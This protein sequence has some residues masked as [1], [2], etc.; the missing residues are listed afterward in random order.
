MKK[1]KHSVRTFRPVLETSPFAYREAYKSLRTNLNFVS[2]NNQYKTIGITSAIPGEGKT[3]ISINL[4]ITLAE[5]GYHIMLVDCD[6]RRPQV[7]K[8]LKIHN[9][10]IGVSTI[11]SG[12]ST[13]EES[14]F[15]PSQFAVG[16]D[17]LCAGLIPPNPAELLGGTKMEE[18][19]AQLK[20]RYDYV[21]FD[22]PPAS[23]VTDSSELS[24]MLD[25]VV[26]VVQQ[27]NT[28]IDL[29][30]DAKKRL[31]SVDA[32]IIGAVLNNYKDMTK[33]SGYRSYRRYGYK[34]G[35]KYGYGYGYGER[36][37]RKK[38]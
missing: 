37:S 31:E 5:A 26:L 1:G 29:V 10:E 6:L 23:L 35:Y 22:T 25:G 15:N 33:G 4:A 13:L 16:V 27:K 11:L 7:H 24:R 20:E 19:I 28:R 3:S 8:Y 2:V 9:N 32:N 21:I 17:V 38:S 34:Y 12:Q 36:S 14:I 18:L 30:M